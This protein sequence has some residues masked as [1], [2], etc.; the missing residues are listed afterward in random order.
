MNF[1]GGEKRTI[2]SW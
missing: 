2:Q 1:S